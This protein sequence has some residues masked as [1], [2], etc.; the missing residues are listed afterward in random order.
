MKDHI[1]ADGAQR[2]RA[3]QEFQ[4]RLQELQKHIRARHVHELKEAGFFRRLVLRW[5]IAWEYRRE[6]RK[7]VPS[8][9][10]L[11]VGHVSTGI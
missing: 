9:Y 4:A 8:A 1:V 3:S 7:I 6:R 10:S 5:H 2:L 11:Y